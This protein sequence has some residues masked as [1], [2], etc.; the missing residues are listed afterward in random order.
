MP[1]LSFIACSVALAFSL[2]ACVHTS[3]R[4]GFDQPLGQLMNINGAA[5]YLG[6]NF[7]LGRFSS[8]PRVRTSKEFADL[9]RLVRTLQSAVGKY[10]A[11]GNYEAALMA[12]HFA[13]KFADYQLFLSQSTRSAVQSMLDNGTGNIDLA[14]GSYAVLP[15]FDRYEAEPKR[16]S[17]N[18]WPYGEVYQIAYNDIGTKLDAAI[19]ILN[20]IVGSPAPAPARQTRTHSG[21][22]SAM[23]LPLNQPVTLTNGAV[24]E[25]TEDSFVLH[26]PGAQPV[27]LDVQQLGYLPPIRTPSKARKMAGKILEQINHTGAE[28]V[29][30]G[31]VQGTNFE[32]P[33]KIIFTINGQRRPGG[34]TVEGR[35]AKSPEEVIASKKEYEKVGSPFRLAMDARYGMERSRERNEFRA[36]CLSIMGRFVF[37]DFMKGAYGEIVDLRCLRMRHKDD[38]VGE[39]IYSR[40]YYVTD[41]GQVKSWESLLRDQDTADKLKKLDQTI[42][43]TENLLQILPVIGN[44]ESG[45][46]CTD[47]PTMTR[48]FL[49]RS[50]DNAMLNHLRSFVSDIYTPADFSAW[51]RSTDCASALPLLGNAAKLGVSAAKLAALGKHVDDYGKSFVSAMKFFDDGL[52]SGKNW[53]AIAAELPLQNQKNLSFAKTMYNGLQRASDMGDLADSLEFFASNPT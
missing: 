19:G 6:G 17:F 34:I 5:A 46:K 22:E 18:D 51:E 12:N 52:K 11:D 32:P 25:R 35:L 50:K 2:S 27:R 13:A 7:D 23:S 45:L 28:P 49:M 42:E 38:M 36:Q 41:A 40:R 21:L 9:N 53:A 16:F 39:L 29:L 10:T 8:L 4:P 30:A 43:A 14:P 48:V 47:T 44:I 37:L 1:K 15:A 24:L 26:N 33:N 31:V 3:T 20:A